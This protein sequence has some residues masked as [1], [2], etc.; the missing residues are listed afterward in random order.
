MS[1][2]LVS[3]CCLTYNHAPFI[4]QCLE[5]FLMQEGVEY[6]IL[7]HDDCSTDGTAEIVKE[8]ATKY[9]DRIFP[10]FEEENQYCKPDR[11]SMDFYNYRRARGKY[12]AYCEG[13]DYWTDPLKLQKQMEFLEA[14]PEYSVC[15]TRNDI[16]DR[17]TGKLIKYQL[18]L[19]CEY[20]EE[21]TK[22]DHLFGRKDVLPLSMVFR[23]SC[24]S[25]E[26]QKH[27]TRYVDSME[28][29]HLL[30]VGRGAILNFVSAVYNCHAGGVS[31]SNT[32]IRRSWENVRDSW[33]MYD[34]IGDEDTRHFYQK[35]LM[36]RLDV[37]E[38]NDMK[39]QYWELYR[40]A[41]SKTPKIAF[42][43]LLTRIKRKIKHFNK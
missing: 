19:E 5:G 38:R 34:Y 10:L 12:I 9:Q 33:E 14:H 39:R 1:K 42:Q 40:F 17:F 18:P 11:E 30:T 28:L 24:F 22:E 13:D 23:R 37:C 27:Y 2:P 43:M 4:R 36:W 31:S 3:I 25:Y 8:Y 41:F 20:M 35:C 15:F 21:I 16:N 7:I 29:Y 6:E 32:A 26:W